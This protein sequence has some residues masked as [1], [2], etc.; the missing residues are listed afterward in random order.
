[1]ITCLQFL[2]C[3]AFICYSGTRLSFYGEVISDKTG[4]GRNWIGL[5]L[6]ATVTSLPELITAISSVTL[7]DFPDLAV[8]GTIGSCLFN[9]LVIAALDVLSRKQ[10]IS[11]VIHQGHMLSAAFGIVL[12]GFVAVDLLA[13]QYLPVMTWLNSSDPISLVYFAGY[14]IAMKLIYSYEKKRVQEFVASVDT[15]GTTSLRHAV[16]FF[17]L[18][19][20]VIVA[21]SCFLPELAVKLA[22]MTGIGQSFI[23]S[24]LVAITTSLPEITVSIAAARMG[25]FDMAVANLLGSNLFNVA[26]LGVTDLFYSKGP[27]LRS[28]AAINGVTAISAM[29]ATAIV[30][31]GLTYRSEK[32]FFYL[33]ADA[34]AIMILYFAVSI[35]LFRAH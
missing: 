25:S 13:S 9:V 21:A 7:N 10:P 22:E 30:I 28:A 23:G 2:L 17:V 14:F 31:I 20:L 29:M 1:M 11:N 26:I 27:L 32:K 24:S 6:L 12:L 8:S 16:L 15:E 4:L 5:V 3:A 19:T 35:L 34:I 18:N 33:A